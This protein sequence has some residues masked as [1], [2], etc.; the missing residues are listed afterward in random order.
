[1]TAIEP[2]SNSPYAVALERFCAR[3]TP[4]RLLALLRAGRTLAPTTGTNPS[5]SPTQE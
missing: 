1:M 2:P 5:N 4:C 3:P